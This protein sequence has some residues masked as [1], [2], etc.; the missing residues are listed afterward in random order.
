MDKKMIMYFPMK[1]KN[2]IGH[3]VS[4]CGCL[5]TTQMSKVAPMAR[6]ALTHMAGIRA[7]WQNCC[8]WVCRLR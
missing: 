8:E 3:P 4:C 2:I 1:I 5:S 7:P 6:H